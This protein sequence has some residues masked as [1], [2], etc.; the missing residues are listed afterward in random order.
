MNRDETLVLLVIIVERKQ[1]D[2][3][4]TALPESGAHLIH[5]T[6]ARGSVRIGSLPCALGLVPEKDKAIILCLL[7]HEK[8]DVILRLLTE[9]FHFGKPNTGI[10]FTV[11]I[12]QL[13]Y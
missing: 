10:A 1:T 13:V 4:L 9:Q 7:T 2:A 5:T 11:P 6:Y 12:D 8:S 3:L